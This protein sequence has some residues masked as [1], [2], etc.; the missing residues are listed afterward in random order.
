MDTLYCYLWVFSSYEEKICYYKYPVNTFLGETYMLFW[1]LLIAVLVV[2]FFV[3]RALNKVDVMEDSALNKDDVKNVVEAVKVD[4]E[5]V[6]DVNKDGKVDVADVKAAGK[7]VKAG[8]KKAAS[9][10]KKPKLKVTK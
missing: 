10:V 6:L 1:I 8:A 2:G 9:K 5:N 7:K 4:V 3:Y